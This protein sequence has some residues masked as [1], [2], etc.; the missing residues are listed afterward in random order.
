VLGR[1]LAPNLARRTFAVRSRRPH[2][3]QLIPMFR[4]PL[5]ALVFVALLAFVPLSADAQN[6]GASRFSGE[7]SSVTTE[8]RLDGKQ[9]GI[10]HSTI[11][12]NSRVSE[13]P[14]AGATTALQSRSR[15]GQTLMIVGGVGFL[16][17]LIIGDS[18]GTALAIGGAVV[19]LYGLYQWS[20]TQ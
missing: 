20:S 8:T 4:M 11:V 2:S 15:Q 13:A 17:G 19:G 14:S 6:A 5:R 16:A 3:R 9:A 18:A 1:T 7:P 12:K 10:S